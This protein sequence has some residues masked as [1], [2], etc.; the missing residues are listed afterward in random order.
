MAKGNLFLGTARRSVGDVVMYRREG[1]QVSRVRV[2]EIANPRTDAQSL[3]RAAFSPV[4]KFYSPLATVLERSWE[5]KNRSQS[6]S[7]FLKENVRQA[8]ANNL[9]LPKGTGFFPLPYMLSYGTLPT[10]SYEF[11][12][13]LVLSMDGITADITTIGA[14]S[15]AFVNSGFA[16]GDIITVILVTQSARVALQSNFV[17][18]AFQFA[19]DEDSTAT[20]NSVFNRNTKFNAGAGLFTFT[21]VSGFA[22]CAGA[23]ISARF[24]NEKWR[25]SSQSL[26]VD[27]GLVS[28]IVSADF[29]AA[30]IASY[31]NSPRGDNPLVYLDGEELTD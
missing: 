14:L 2:R 28:E 29:R 1:S 11:N 9:L 20:L 4:A 12:A 19:V 23:I 21:E 31:G 6:Y 7:A 3:Q 24:E 15:T 16:N 17:P 8:K 13:G 25:R 5:G 27:E 30:A 10:L 18:Y 22:V 26:S